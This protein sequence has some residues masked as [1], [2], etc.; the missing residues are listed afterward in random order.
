[1]QVANV[2]RGVLWT[3]LGASPF[4]MHVALGTERLSLA[5]S[6]LAA[7]QVAL[8]GLVLFR[9]SRRGRVAWLLLAVPAFLLASRFLG[10]VSVLAVSGVSHTLIYTGLFAFFARTLRPGRVDLCTAMAARLRGA[11]APE[12]AAY[13]RNVTIAWCLFFAFQLVAS[14]TLVLLAPAQVWSLF[15]NVLELPLVAG[16]FLVELAIRRLR[17]RSYDHVGIA[18]TV[19]AFVGQRSAGQRG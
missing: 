2:A 11:L 4:V 10:H 17:F 19:R 12:M 8:I 14:L 15:V 7:L 1:M 13:T 9:R 5:A 3:A 18:E 16:M 6:L